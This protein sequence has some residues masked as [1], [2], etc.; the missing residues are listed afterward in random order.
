M[1]NHHFHQKQN[2]QILH[3]M[4]LLEKGNDFLKSI[5]QLNEDEA[6]LIY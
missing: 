6:D 3:K 2:Q 4:H 1:H 5:L